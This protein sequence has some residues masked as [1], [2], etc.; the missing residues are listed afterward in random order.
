MS[1]TV[2]LPITCSCKN[3]RE[4]FYPLKVEDARNGSTI[5]SMQIECP[6]RH[7][8]NCLQQLTIQ[9]PPGMKPTNDE[10]ILR[11]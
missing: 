7:E 4:F 10:N 2:P 3:K 9:L 5:V 1:K 6:F 11:K 8:K